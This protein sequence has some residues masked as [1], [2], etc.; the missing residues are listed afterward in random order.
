MP[1]DG[2]YRGIVRL[3]HEDA[4]TVPWRVGRRVGRTIYAVFSD[5]EDADGELI[6]MMDSRQLAAAACEAHNALLDRG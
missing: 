4:L 6:G 3:A 1:S 5:E 2:T